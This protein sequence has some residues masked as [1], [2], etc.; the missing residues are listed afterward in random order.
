MRLVRYFVERLLKAIGP[1]PAIST[2][3]CMSCELRQD[4]HLPATRR[5]LC[6]EARALRAQ[7]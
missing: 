5:R 1:Q 3:L 4:C 7:P 2:F 6:C